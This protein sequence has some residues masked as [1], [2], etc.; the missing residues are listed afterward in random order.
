MECIVLKTQKITWKIW[1]T[2][3][4]FC[5]LNLFRIL[6]I[7]ICRLCSSYIARKDLV[8]NTQLSLYHALLNAFIHFTQF[9]LFCFLVPKTGS[10]INWALQPINSPVFFLVIAIITDFKKAQPFCYISKCTFFISFLT[11][12]LSNN[13]KKIIIIIIIIIL[14][15]GEGRVASSHIRTLLFKNF[16][17][18]Q[19]NR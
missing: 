9:F 2:C 8:H 5:P 7:L 14:K 18:C 17:S 11:S 13:K 10:S 4:H 1:H 15:N 16:L 6:Y 19:G 3:W 12:L